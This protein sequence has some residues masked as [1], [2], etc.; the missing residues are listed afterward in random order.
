[1]RLIEELTAEGHGYP[2]LVRVHR[3]GGASVP[4]LR[5]KP[6]ERKLNPPGISVLRADTPGKAAAEMR[7]AYPEATGLHETAR[8]IGSATLAAVR[9]AG[10]E[11]LPNRTRRLPNHHRLVHPAGEAGFSDENL[12]RLTAAFTNTTGH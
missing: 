3:I 11:V 1:M 8:A 2:D 7:E 9:E 6:A 12:A 10:F 4:N 5:L